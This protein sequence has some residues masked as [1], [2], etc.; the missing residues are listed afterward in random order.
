M[1]II[2]MISNIF[3]ITKSWF[4][5]L[6]HILYNIFLILSVVHISHT[7]SGVPDTCQRCWTFQ[8][9]NWHTIKGPTFSLVL[10][11]GWTP[12]WM[13]LTQ[14]F[15]TLQKKAMD[16]VVKLQCMTSKNVKLYSKTK[17]K[18]TM[19]IFIN[20]LIYSF[21]YLFNHLFILNTILQLI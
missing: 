13:S 1:T 5:K 7:N 6:L 10:L 8:L 14:E 2:K 3:S 15:N 21:I 18:S 9:F 11:L 4:L 20:L 19:N 12:F 16:N 17:F